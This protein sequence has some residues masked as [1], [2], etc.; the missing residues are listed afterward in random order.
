M[1]ILI[2]KETKYMIHGITGNEGLFYA[3]QMMAN[4]ADIVAGV[5]PGK[6]GEWVLDGKIPV[7][8]LASMAIEATGANAS[9]IFV[10]A[11]FAPDA[12][13]E[14]ADAGVELIICVTE[15]IPIKDVIRVKEILSRTKT[16]LI[17]PS[18]PGILTPGESCA[19]VI[20]G[21]IIRPG[22][23]GVVSR[24]GTLMYEILLGLEQA[25]KGVSTCVG[26]G[27]DAVLGTSLK[28]VVSLFQRDAQTEKIILVG[29]IGGNAEEEV[30]EYVRN[31]T[32]KPIIAIVAGQTAPPGKQM[33]HTG[34][35]IEWDSGIAR[36][37]ISALLAAGVN[38]AESLEEIPAL[39]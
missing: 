34:A 15:G 10:P 22:K 14:A 35:M 28:D 18:S 29:E 33:G 23:V 24:S 4:G 37:K 12:I 19:G 5:T 16:R 36:D 13:L 17:G 20:P 21:D 26:L 2:N 38:I 25:G 32:T 30:A 1:G 11:R 7:F 27:G 8:D 39:L 31:Q 3:A 6:G 9:I